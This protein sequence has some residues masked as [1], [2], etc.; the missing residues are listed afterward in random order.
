[1]KAPKGTLLA[2]FLFVNFIACRSVI[3]AEAAAMIITEKDVV[4]KSC[5]L[6]GGPDSY[7]LGFRFRGKTPEEIQAFVR[8]KVI[9]RGTDGSTIEVP[10]PAILLVEGGK[11][12]GLILD[13]RS[14]DLGLRI[15]K[16]LDPTRTWSDK[17][18][19]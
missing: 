10:L 8:K 19:H 4:P 11:P 18:S 7:N 9:I 12:I 1:M 5:R 6:G 13:I 15:G 3:G 16:I 17:P 14:R 2:F